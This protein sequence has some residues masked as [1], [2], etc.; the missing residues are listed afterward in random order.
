MPK[1]K[2]FSELEDRARQEDSGWDQ[3][4]AAIRRAIEDALDL[5]GD[6]D[7]F[8]TP[9]AMHV[10]MLSWR[11]M[12]EE[13][14]GGKRDVLVSLGRGACS[15]GELTQP[16]ERRESVLQPGA[17]SGRADCRLRRGPAACWSHQRWRG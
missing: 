3:D 5:G 12:D 10:A 11:S 14:G 13:R 7:A 6:T 4:A 15:T 17:G 9:D 2:P 8:P 16:G 1:T